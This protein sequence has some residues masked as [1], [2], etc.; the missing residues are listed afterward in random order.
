M[1]Y[2]VYIYMIYNV[3]LV[4]AIQLSDSVIHIHLFFFRFFPHI[5]YYKILNRV[6]CAIQ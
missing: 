4:S 1:I 6:P 2:I 3:V 5:G